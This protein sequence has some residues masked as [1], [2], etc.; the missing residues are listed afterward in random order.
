MQRVPGLAVELDALANIAWV[1][2]GRPRFAT[3]IGV[4][5][6]PVLPLALPVAALVRGLRLERDRAF[7]ARP[8]DT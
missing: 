7:R 1:L 6:R 5:R 4:E 8:A 3:P 2:A